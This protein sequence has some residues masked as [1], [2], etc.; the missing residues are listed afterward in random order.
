MSF[1]SFNLKNQSIDISKFGINF[2]Q[3]SQ[4]NA[5]I[6]NKKINSCKAK[7][8]IYKENHNHTK[9]DKENN[10]SEKNIKSNIESAK[11]N[12]TNSRYD[13]KIVKEHDDKLFF[14]DPNKLFE[15]IINNSESKYIEFLIGIIEDIINIMS[16]ILYSPPYAILFGRINIEKPKPQ[17]KAP[18][19]S[20]VEINN[21]FYEGFGICI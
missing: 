12:N 10:Y 13:F 6:K 16:Q 11:E 20:L 18:D 4:S 21:L 8:K 5:I 3:P 7:N 19:Y 15:F 14:D 1:P 9:L 17:P 2:L